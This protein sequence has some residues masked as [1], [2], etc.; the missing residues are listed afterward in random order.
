[1]FTTH[2]KYEEYIPTKNDGYTKILSYFETQIFSKNK[3]KS[4]TFNN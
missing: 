2:K 3:L 1:M 4:I